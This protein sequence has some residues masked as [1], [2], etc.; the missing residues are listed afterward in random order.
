[1][2]SN[3]NHKKTNEQEAIVICISL[4]LVLELVLELVPQ[5][6]KNLPKY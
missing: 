6:K 2:Y 3:L 5:N 4:Q 1:M